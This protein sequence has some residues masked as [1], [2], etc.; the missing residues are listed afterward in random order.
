MQTESVLALD[1]GDKRIGVAIV[2]VGSTF[3]RPLTTLQHDDSIWQQLQELATT[4]AANLFVVGL[5][6]DLN[7]QETEQTAK[8][9][10]FVSALQQQLAVTVQL[11]DEAATSIKAERELQARG[12]PYEKT[13][14]D[15]LAATYIL[16]DYVSGAHHV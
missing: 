1:V 7:G 4:H 6:R 14:I 16:E 15:A 12:K 3:P 2:A 13:A 8:V 10:A 5:P 11:Q 9:R